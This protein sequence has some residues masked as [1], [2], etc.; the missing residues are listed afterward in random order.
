MLEADLPKLLP[1]STTAGHAL[2]GSFLR[3]SYTLVYTQ[4]CDVINTMHVC[5]ASVSTRA[6]APTRRACGGKSMANVT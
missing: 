3:G 6:A 2:I 1:M 4:S 5:P